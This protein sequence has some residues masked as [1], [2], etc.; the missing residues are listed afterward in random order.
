MVT[1]YRNNKLTQ[2]IPAGIVKT[3]KKKKKKNSN[4]PWKNPDENPN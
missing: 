3:F 2:N 4:N 1:G